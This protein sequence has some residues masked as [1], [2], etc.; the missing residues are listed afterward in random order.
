M[1]RAALLAAILCA[2]AGVG[3]ISGASAAQKTTWIYFHVHMNAYAHWGRCHSEKYGNDYH[4]QSSGT[5]WGTMEAGKL[6]SMI[7]YG[8]YHSDA[9]EW[10]WSESTND[11]RKFKLTLSPG[12]IGLLK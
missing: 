5:C 9:A 6:G 8:D 1:R 2:V 11:V 10:D 3:Q 7:N 4:W 12:S